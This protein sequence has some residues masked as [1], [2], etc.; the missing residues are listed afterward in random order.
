MMGVGDDTIDMVKTNYKVLC[1]DTINNMTDY[2]QEGS[3]FALKI[4]YTVTG[5]RMMIAIRYTYNVQKVIYFISTEESEITKFGINYLYMYPEQFD[6][7]S[8]RPVSGTLFIYKFFV[9][10]NDVDSHNKPRQ[11]YL[12]L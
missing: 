4:N 9:S 10:V 3:Y 12:A 5:Y 2:F 7:I 6:N 1:K 11:S 8:I